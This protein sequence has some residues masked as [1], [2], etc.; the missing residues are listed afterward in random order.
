MKGL[1]LSP[2]QVRVV[3]DIHEREGRLLNALR[4]L[5][6]RV[7]RERLLVGDYR[8]GGAVVE[9]K[10]VSDLHLSI[11]DRRLWRQISR[12]RR[13]SLQPYLLVEGESLDAG[14]L[15]TA[16][17]RGALIAVAELDVGLIRS[18]NQEDSAEWLSLLAV[19][20][21]RRRRAASV[22]TNG[23]ASR[24][25]AEGMLAAVPGLSVVSARALL[26]CFGSIAAIAEA[27][28]S[29]WLSVPGIGPVRAAS[30][31]KAIHQYPSISSRAQ[32][33]RPDPST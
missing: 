25:A 13:E 20:S 19:R 17:I 18:A 6:V 8:T 16:S 12:L 3:V 4:S 21:N 28:P 10:T 1:R 29:S 27:N 15:S 32:S 14:P 2:V 9:R 11:I 5:G 7:A 31:E 26:T 22:L 33:A 24:D 23:I 30:L